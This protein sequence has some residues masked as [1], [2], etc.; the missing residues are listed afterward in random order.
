MDSYFALIGLFVVDVVMKVWE[1]SY[2]NTHTHTH[3]HTYTYIYIYIYIY[4]YTYIHRVK[5]L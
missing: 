1:K 5:P 4:I 2:T 3:T